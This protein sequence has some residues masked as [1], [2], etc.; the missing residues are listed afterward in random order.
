MILVGTVERATRI[1]S[2]GA[3]GAVEGPV[4][5][6]LRKTAVCRGRPE[7]RDDVRAT[8]PWSRMRS[9]P[10][11]RRTKAVFAAM[12]AWNMASS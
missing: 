2:E 7:G 9:G 5:G 12:A 8:Y 1:G 3:H 11:M 4:K 10:A 6:T